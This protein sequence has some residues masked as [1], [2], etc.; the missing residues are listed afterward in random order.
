LDET[1]CSRL[2]RPSL[3]SWS[4]AGK[5]LR[6][7][8]RSVAKD[9]PEPKA[10]SCYGLYVPEFEKPWLRFVDGR[11]VSGVTTRFLEWCCGKLEK[12]PAKGFGC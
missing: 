2:V 4:D 6:L 5:P 9:D 10:L 11:P 3:N 7:V 12:R 1:W 8:E